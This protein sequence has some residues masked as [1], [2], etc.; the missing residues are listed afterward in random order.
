M[1]EFF[2]SLPLWEEFALFESAKIMKQKIDL[3][4]TN[5]LNNLAIGKI[6]ED[7]VYFIKSIEVT[8]EHLSCDEIILFS[9]NIVSKILMR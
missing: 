9:E 2:D 6:I 3:N 8:E 5:T 1:S 4:L 7:E